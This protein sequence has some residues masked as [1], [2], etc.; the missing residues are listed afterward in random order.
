MTPEELNRKMEFIVEVQA[1]TSATL[2]TMAAENAEFKRWA[3]NIV[4]QLA[5]DHQR[6][7][8]LVPIQSERLDQSEQRLRQ[9]ER[10]LDRAERED[11]A[12]QK[13]HEELLKE[14]RAP[15]IAFSTNFQKNLTS[16]DPKKRTRTVHFPGK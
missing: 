13:R 9:S 7:V 3:K 1:R 4:T 8:E 10:R 2:D 5:A 11:Q 15:L 16:G 14:M 6:M 12:A